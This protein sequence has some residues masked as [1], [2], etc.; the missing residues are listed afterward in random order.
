LT[1]RSA[2]HDPVEEVFG[3][4]AV[5]PPDLAGDDA[6]KEEVRGWLTALTRHGVK[7]TLVGA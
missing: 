2:A 1:V 3:L 5:F 6:L 4:S 7:D